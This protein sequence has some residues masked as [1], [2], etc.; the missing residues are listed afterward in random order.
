VSKK[1]LHKVS[2]AVTKG[3][4]EMLI[5]LIDVDGHDFPNDYIKEG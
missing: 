2:Q 1:R 5:G 4:E 3:A